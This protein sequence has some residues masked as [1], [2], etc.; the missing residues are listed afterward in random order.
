MSPPTASQG[1][2]H[3]SGTRGRLDDP[4]AG[5]AVPTDGLLVVADDRQLRS[6]VAHLLFPQ[7]RDAVIA[8]A[9]APHASEPPLSA[10]DARSIVGP[11]VRIYLVRDE[12]ILARLDG[13]LG[14]RLGLGA[15]ASRIWWPGL[16]TS[17][18]PS[19]HPLIMPL[20][21]DQTL[22]TML[23]GAFRAGPPPNASA[24][25]QDQPGPSD[26]VIGAQ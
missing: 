4:D 26:E 14:P 7:R 9:T 18:R 15:G 25:E 2:R 13:A 24:R 16:S 1:R 20:R 8:L 21:S 22:S 10:Q 5:T 3:L 12:L 23:A 11:S 17:S 19:D 6:M